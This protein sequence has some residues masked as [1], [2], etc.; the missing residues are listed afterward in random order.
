[1]YVLLFRFFL[2]L[3]YPLVYLYLKTLKIRII[4][5]DKSAGAFKSSLVCSCYH[6]NLIPL[7]F[8]YRNKNY[9]GLVSKKM[10]G[11]IADF[12]LNKF[13]YKTIRGSSREGGTEALYEIIP[14][15]KNN[16]VIS[17]PFDGPKGPVYRMKK[18]I[19]W[20]ANRA[21]YPLLFGYCYFSKAWRLWN[22]DG[23]YIPYPFSK[24]L[25]VF[26]EPFFVEGKLHKKDLDSYKANI[27]K[28][29]WNN[30][31]KFSKLFQET[32]GFEPVNQINN[33]NEKN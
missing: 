14:L 1:M 27:E 33:L 16:I 3:A 18:G 31:V 2:F 4:A 28:K 19:I 26:D 13:G 30:Y 22:W 20:L 5:S 25:I 8:A 21:K 24:A 29:M 9:F 10:D 15:L 7:I 12:Y 6:N 32:F 23:L 11:E 17:I